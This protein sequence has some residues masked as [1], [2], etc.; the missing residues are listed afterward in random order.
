MWPV[1]LM[2]LGAAALAFYLDSETESEERYHAELRRSNEDLRARI[3]Q[4]MREQAAPRDIA[5]LARELSCE[6]AVAMESYLGRLNSVDGEFSALRAQLREDLTDATISP[7]RRN[8]LQLLQARL[9][10]ACNRLEAYRLY[11]SWYLERQKQLLDRGRYAE[12]LDL[13]VPGSRL[14]EDWFY[15]GKLGLIEVPEIGERNHYGQVLQLLE[16]KQGEHYS[17]A[18]QRALLLQHPDQDAIPV[19]LLASKNPRYFKA[20]LLRGALY[21]EHIQQRRPCL[22]IVTRSTGSGA[23]GEG[24]EVR[25]FPSFC[26]VNGQLALT[27]GVRAFLPLSESAFPGKRYHAGER[28]EVLLHHH[29][30]LLQ[31]AV[32][33]TQQAESLD[34]GSSS[35]A[36]QANSSQVSAPVWY[37]WPSNASRAPSR[38]PAS[39]SRAP[40]M[41]PRAPAAVRRRNPAQAA[42][43]AQ[44]A[45]RVWAP[46]NRWTLLMSCQLAATQQMAALPSSKTPSQRVLRAR[47]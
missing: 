29:G 34:Q 13:G 18:V 23:R 12:L 47:N 44:T 26:T 15:S 21:V 17:D 11:G 33:L 6:R 3:N 41:A 1:I 40:G 39:A 25:C 16:D 27:S 42:A 31:G 43:S 24:Y 38:M 28:L 14:P 8:S 32:T 9:D 19:Q 35:T 20:C 45:N 37:V 36:H 22:G 10:D 5:R 2:S 4:A 7:F 30:L 46:A